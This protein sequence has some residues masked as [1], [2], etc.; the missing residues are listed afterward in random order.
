MRTSDFDSFIIAHFARPKSE[1][2][3]KILKVERLLMYHLFYHQRSLHYCNKQEVYPYT[4]LY[5]LSS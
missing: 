3:S 5:D 4:Y 1:I 2:T